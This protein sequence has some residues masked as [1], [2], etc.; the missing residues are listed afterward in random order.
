MVPFQSFSNPGGGGGTPVGPKTFIW[1]GCQGGSAQDKVDVSWSS[2]K[3]WKV[4]GQFA[5]FKPRAIDSCV[6][7]GTGITCWPEIGR[8]SN[9]SLI[10]KSLYIA[11]GAHI[12]YLSTGDSLSVYKNLV[13]DGIIYQDTAAHP[14]YFPSSNASISGNGTFTNCSISVTQKGN[15]STLID[16]DLRALRIEDGGR[17]HV[18]G[19]I[20]AISKTLNLVSTNKNGI[21]YLENG[22]L[23]YSNSVSPVLQGNLDP[24]SGLFWYNASNKPQTAA[25][26][27]YYN[28]KTNISAANLLTIGTTGTLTIGNSFEIAQGNTVTS[29]F[30]CL[31]AHIDL[32]SDLN[33]PSFCKLDAYNQSGAIATSKVFDIYLKGDWNN[34]GTYIAR[35]NTVNFTG[36]NLQNINGS[37]NSVF[38]NL[39]VDKAA[40]ALNLNCSPTVAYND[41]SISP[42]LVAS[43]NLTKGNI[44]LNKNTLT[45]AEKSSLGIIRSTG[46]IVSEDIS[47]NALSK[48]NNASKV[49]WKIGNDASNHLIPFGLVSGEYIPFEAKNTN[50]TV[51]GDL[52]V[53][54]FHTSIVEPNTTLVPIPATVKHILNSTGGNNSIY[55]VKRF[56]QI[57]RSNGGAP[58][59]NMT[60][61]FTYIDGGANDE[62]A[63]DGS[64]GG[65]EANYRAQRFDTANSQWDDPLPNQAADASTNTVLVTG[66]T[67]FSP[68]SISKLVSPL[69]LQLISFKA[70]KLENNINV[71]WETASELNLSHFE[72]EKLQKNSFVQITQLDSKGNANLARSY[73]YIDNDTKA[74]Q[75]TY[76]LKMVDDNGQATYSYLANITLIDRYN[77]IKIYPSPTSNYISIE[78]AASGST[79]Y[80][81]DINGKQI[82]HLSEGTQ[83]DISS[84]APGVYWLKA[85][86]NSNNTISIEK[87]VKI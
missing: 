82:M 25:T 15:C 49:T 58:L 42:T 2:A 8:I 68:W 47:V 37:S 4:D 6:V 39:V 1:F 13:N 65:R 29:G 5:T 35:S 11:S 61:K 38:F 64:A 57:D 54:T 23:R 70:S 9:S 33:I 59:P 31:G 16:L 36:S 41:A 52:T 77:K 87:I 74:T 81:L 3:N 43:L 76:R 55:L 18:N 14:I 10:C 40:N 60:V 86:N 67:Q 84:L 32:S 79:F 69:P 24:R 17:F 12:T 34:N 22:E 71:K 53:S 80:I 20:V 21:L 62:L 73:S 48:A 85:V 45:I 56:W 27:T 50:G 78:G 7:P 66:I 28:L 63:S 72:L 19:R 51:F 44:L 26:A 30:A 75:H 83:M 46:A